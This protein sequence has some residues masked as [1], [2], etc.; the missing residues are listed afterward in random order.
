V[1][2]HLGINR[3][4][5]VTLVKPEGTCSQLVNSSSG[6]HPRFSK[7]YIRRVRISATDPLAKFLIASGV[8]H[9]PE[10][11]QQ[12]PNPSTWVFD[13]PIKSPDGALTNDDTTALQ[14]LDYWLM[15][16][17]SFCEH[18]PSSSIFYKESEIIPVLAW[19]KEHWKYVG[20]LAFFPANDH[21]YALA[22]YE[23]IDEKTYNELVDKFPRL[24][25][26]GSRSTRRKTQ[27]TQKGKRGALGESV[28]MFK[29]LLINYNFTSHGLLV[30]F[31][32]W[33]QASSTV[34]AKV[35]TLLHR[36]VV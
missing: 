5:A 9:N 23:K 11:S 12:L 25:L 14:M 19:L 10:T 26:T 31:S 16:K 27:Q 8:T 33:Y 13:F 1:G 18:N 4:S 21:V 17:R 7:F 20:G 22:P 34:A 15:V 2:V 3:S 28:T 32:F 29:E 24:T 36:G 35:V 30:E 6:V